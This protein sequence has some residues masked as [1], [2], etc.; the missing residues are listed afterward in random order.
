MLPQFYRTC[1]QSRL[2]AAQLLTLEIVVWILQFHK[3]V[4]IERLAAL[5]PQ[6]ILF[7]SRRRHLQRFLRLPQLS[8]PLLW[9]PLIKWIIQTHYKKATRLLVAIDRTQ[10]KQNNLFMVSVIWEK[11]AWPIYWQFLDKQGSSNL[12]EQQALLRPVLRLLRSYEIVVIG[13]REFRI[14]ELANW[15]QQ[16]NVYFA[17]R[18]K[19]DNY[20]QRPGQDYQPLHSLGLAPGM[21]LYLT[22]VKVTKKK[23]F[24]S[25]DIAAYWKRKYRNRVEEQGWYILTNLGSLSAA[26][27]AYKA[28]S[29]IEAMFKDCKSGGYNLEGSKATIERLT[30]LVL[31]I[32]LAYTCASLSGRKIKQLGQQKYVSRLTELGRTVRRHSSFWVGLYGQVWMAGME[33]LSDLVSQLM[34]IKPNKLPFFQRGLRAMALIQSTS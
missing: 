9:F 6:P 3:Q 28:R 8:I 18:Q 22:G 33:F 30:S 19:Q 12:A 23:G 7:E 27:D 15:L 13:D 14:V 21:K 32:A 2:S 16:R 29:G 20:I 25:F 4:R 17:F 11:R 31:I 26:V 24:G 34:R 5:F 10:W 1:L